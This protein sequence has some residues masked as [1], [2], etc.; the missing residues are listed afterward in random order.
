MYTWLAYTSP[1]RWEHVSLSGDFL[2]DRAAA[3]AGKRRVLNF[4][5]VASELL[6]KS[7]CYTT[8][9]TFTE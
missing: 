5:L 9:N 8:F 4:G 1:L 7:N 2:W 3:T 6:P